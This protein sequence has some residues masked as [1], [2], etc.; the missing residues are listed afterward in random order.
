MTNTAPLS[1]RIAALRTLFDEAGYDVAVTYERTQGRNY[2]T[3]EPETYEEVAC[4]DNFGTVVAY[5]GTDFAPEAAFV[6]T[7]RAA[8]ENGNEIRSP[9]LIARHDEL[10]AQHG[11]KK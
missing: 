10:I 6:A 9:A 7:V 8:R 5:L 2:V 11:F 3:N 1:D 4:Y